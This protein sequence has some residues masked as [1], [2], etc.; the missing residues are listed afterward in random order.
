LDWIVMKCLEKDRDRRYESAASLADDARRHLNYEPVSAVAPSRIYRTRKFIRRNKWPVIAAAAVLLGLIA[1]IIGTTIGLV[2]QSHQRA[3]AERERAEAQLN[4]AVA[5][6]AQRDYAM[7]EDVYRQQLASSSPNT[8]ADRH[9][10]ALARLRLAEIVGDTRGAAASEPLFREALAAYR[11]AFSG[12]GA[13]IALALNSLALILRNQQKFAEAEP[14]FREAYDFH[15]HSARANHRAIG[16]S[17]ANLANVLTTLGRYG[18]A[19]QLAREAIAHHLRAVP[20]DI[21]ALAF[22]R[23]ELGRD[24]IVMGRFADAEREL[25][26]AQ[27][28]AATTSRFQFGPLSL[29]ALYTK[30][31]QAEPGKGY[32]AKAQQSIRALIRTFVSL[33]EPTIEANTK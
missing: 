5:L 6:H 15:R 2:S 30:W 23:V 19:E 32:D 21:W 13:N 33:D 1:G 14:L 28:L 10:I 18:E 25:L 9:R 24:L 16:E 7:A 31:D 11:D 3:I 4:F 27:Q 20:Q 22:A 8:P 29:A 12:D 26:E 17:A